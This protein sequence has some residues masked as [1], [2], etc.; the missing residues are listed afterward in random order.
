MSAPHD[1]QPELRLT[2]APRPE[3]VELLYRT[4]GDVLIPLE[5]LRTR[6]F[7]NLNEDSF[8][9]A[10]KAKRIALPLTTLDPSRKAPLF[11]DVRHLAALID[12]RAWQADEAYAQPGSNE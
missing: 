12:S 4:F 8:S 5:Q 9:L 6:Y 2:P 3:T 11:V 10:I 1:N 7:R